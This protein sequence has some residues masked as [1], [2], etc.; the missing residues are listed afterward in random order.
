MLESTD[1]RKVASGG[2][3]DRHNS[4]AWSMAWFRD[5]LYVGT[6][7]DIMW[8]FG[9][10]GGHSYFDPFPV[11]LSPL[12]EMDLRAQIWRYSPATKEWDRVYTSPLTTPSLR[13]AVKAHRATRV[14]P[15]RR[16]PKRW[17]LS[18]FMTRRRAR[19]LVREVLRLWL[20]LARSGFK[21]AVGRDLGYRNIVVHTDAHGAESMC[22][23]SVGAGGR[24]LRST[25]G[26]TFDMT[27]TFPIRA[28]VSLKGR[29]FASSM[30]S[31]FS[32][33]PGVLESEDPAGGATVA[34]SWRPASEPGF[35][36]PENN[37]IF[38]MVAFNGHLYAGT[39]NRSGFQIWKAN[40]EGTPPY[41]WK[42][43]VGGG[44]YKGSP[45]PAMV[46]SMHPFGEWLY[47]GCG[48]TLS[49]R[50]VFDPSPGELIRIAPDDTWEVIAGSGRETDQGFKAP[51]SGL[52]AGFGNQLA[53]YVWRMET[54]GGWLYAGTNDATT[55]L[56]YTPKDR[57]GPQV[58]RWVEQHGGVE[59]TLEA[60]AGFD[61]WRTQDG[62]RWTCVTRRGF[63]SPLHHGARTLQST[64]A[65]LF[66]G[67]ASN[68]FT[69]TTDPK[70]G[71][72]GG[73]ADIWLGAR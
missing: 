67:T 63:D 55:F 38:E 22:V 9:K 70:T 4:Y 64:P 65:G 68:F 17:R 15:G 21:I 16:P 44:G 36:D 49:G 20:E 27:P 66:L 14:F 42:K 28:L 26:S 61:L 30:R 47:V 34:E 39:T 12:A 72:P 29:L 50:D 11:P 62:I 2:F 60:E 19:V 33:Y 57:I 41:R 10:V 46:L 13:Q 25:D 40:P 37:L 59:K 51:I 18:N 23:A 24:L 43:V 8:L 52:G 54:H 48:R 6:N 1:F 35:G 3:G 31:D 5:R 73:G 45:G 32:A 56:R 71:Q 58:A 7:R 53:M 69:D